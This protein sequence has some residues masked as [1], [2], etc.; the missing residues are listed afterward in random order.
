MGI[1][2]A[3]HSLRHIMASVVSDMFPDA[4][5]GI[6]PAIENGFYY[7]FDLPRTLVVEITSCLRKICHIATVDR[8]IRFWPLRLCA[9]L[10]GEALAKTGARD[11]FGSLRAV[12]STSRKPA[13]PG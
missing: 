9:F 6:G 5:L 3:R 10:P 13:S 2:T 8:M 4:K 11:L 1:E 12:G 7:D